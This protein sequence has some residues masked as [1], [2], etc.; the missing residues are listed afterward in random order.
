MCLYRGSN[1][2]ILPGVWE[3]DFRSAVTR[4]DSGYERVSNLSNGCGTIRAAIRRKLA[5]CATVILSFVVVPFSF[6]VQSHFK[7]MY[8]E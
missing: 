5:I 8:A 2:Q 4:S 6:D 7:A 1:F 3:S